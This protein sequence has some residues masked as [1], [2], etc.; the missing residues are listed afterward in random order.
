MS[1]DRSQHFDV[2]VIGSGGG[3]KITRPAANLGNRTAIIDSG[4]LGGTCLNHGCIPSKMLSHPADIRLAIAESN[5]YELDVPIGTVRFKE[6]VTRVTNTIMADSAKIA[7]GYESHP[8]IT[9]FPHHA[10]FVGPK[11][12][13][14][15]GER[16]T[17]DKIFITV[18]AKAQ[19][20][21]IPGLKDTPYLTYKEALRLTSQPKKM[22]IL[23]AGYI[24][25]ELGHFYGA[26]GTEVTYVVRSSFLRNEDQEVSEAITANFQN[27]F[28]CHMKSE[29]SQVT[30][31]NGMFT[32]TIETL[33]GRFTEQADALLIA[34]GVL[35]Y[36]DELGLDTTGVSINAAGAIQV[37]DY[38]ETSCKGIWAFGDVIGRYLF[39]HTANFEGDY[40][41]NT[42]FG[43]QDK[44]PI[45]YPPVPHAVFCNPQ[46]AGV[47][48]TEQALIQQ[49]TPYFVGKNLYAHSGMGMALRSTDEFV[50]LLFHRDT[51]TLLGA[52][53]YGDEAATMIHMLIAMMG[54]KATLDDLL[55][56]IYIHPALPEVV[57]NAARKAKAAQGYADKTNT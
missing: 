46:I 11:T 50:K 35:P 32:V 14:V 22:I 2:I 53:I 37:D 9:Y 56:M 17:G 55:G 7:P 52:H 21:Y 48:A 18:G 38:M 41:C 44:K 57:R 30:Y 16:I 23:G 24:A 33:N 31:E 8:N 29:I 3:S 49:N 26:M 45:S 1:T 51:K 19:I 6:L 27:R 4:Y 43:G 34:T 12:I 47:G 54:K 15:N 20:P 13:E 10:K 39:R 36:T 25:C 42:V 28:T 40:V 5:K